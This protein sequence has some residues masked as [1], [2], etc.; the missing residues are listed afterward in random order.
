[1]DGRCFHLIE[2]RWAASQV[3]KSS[4]KLND[5]DAQIYHRWLGMDGSCEQWAC[6]TCGYWWTWSCDQ[7]VRGSTGHQPFWNSN[8]TC[9]LHCPSSHLKAG[10]PS[11]RL[12]FLRTMMT[13]T[14]D[15]RIGSNQF[16]LLIFL[17]QDRCLDLFWTPKQHWLILVVWWYESSKK[18]LFTC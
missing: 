5:F 14:P 10:V 17:K 1:M 11:W 9:R 8:G 15:F 13:A 18:T 6:G 12:R 7:T 3:S 4:S 2:T 16:L